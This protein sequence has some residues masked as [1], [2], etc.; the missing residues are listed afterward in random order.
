[1]LGSSSVHR[2]PWTALISSQSLMNPFFCF[3]LQNHSKSALIREAWTHVES[4]RKRRYIRGV[5][6]KVNLSTFQGEKM[7][8][9]VRRFAPDMGRE[10]IFRYLRLQSLPRSS[11]ALIF[12]MANGKRSLCVLYHHSDSTIW[13]YCRPLRASQP[14]R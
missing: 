4:C 2:K 9:R 5:R 8:W 14:Q 6:R 1:M 12:H 10:V 11:K 13:L 3:Q 7:D